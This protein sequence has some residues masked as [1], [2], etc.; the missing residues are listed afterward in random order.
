MERLFYFFYQYR[1]FF[2][3]LALELFAAWLIV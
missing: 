3:F 1:A 2:T